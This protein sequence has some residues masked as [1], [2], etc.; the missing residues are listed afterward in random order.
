[1]KSSAN[2][3]RRAGTVILAVGILVLVTGIVISLT[4][5]TQ[6][7]PIFLTSSILINSLGIILLQAGKK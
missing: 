4:I 5:G 7:V 1:M 6:L 3:V 2:K